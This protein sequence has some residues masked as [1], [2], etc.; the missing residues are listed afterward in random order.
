M[1][2]I[3]NNILFELILFNVAQLQ[4]ISW[5]TLETIEM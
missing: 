4:I 5:Y 3:Y 1:M 2:S